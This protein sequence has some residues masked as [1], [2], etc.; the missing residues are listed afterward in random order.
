MNQAIIT[1]SWDDGFPLDLKMAELLLKYDT[2]A[3]FYI[4]IENVERQSMNFAEISHIARYFDVGGH[5]YHH[6]DLTQASRTEAEKEIF[7]GKEKLENIIGKELFAF[8]YPMGRYDYQI[9][10]I[11][12]TAGFEGA[13]TTKSFIRRIKDPFLTGT[14]VHARDF[15][16]AHY[17][18]TALES[19]DVG[20]SVYIL[21]N[22][23]YAK[24]WDQIAMETL[25]YVVK[26]GGVW[27]LWGHSWEIDAQNDWQRLTGVLHKIK[28]L[29]KRIKKV[30]NSQLIKMHLDR[31]R[32]IQSLK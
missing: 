14:T 26:N 27:H 30:N 9:K 8:C 5:T 11:V 20:L 32:G 4:P 18:T 24:K 29:S 17:I 23:L 22:R 21:K 19:L 31:N 3:T 10:N 15:T 13:R 7:A 2:P 12:K 6:T 28:M 25:D 1:T 16:S